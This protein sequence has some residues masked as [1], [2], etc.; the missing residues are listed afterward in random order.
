[1][2]RFAVEDVIA[3]IERQAPT[4]GVDP[5]FARA[6]F[7]AENS[8]DGV[9]RK[10]HV[11]G[12]IKSPVGARGVM[13]TMPDTE[14]GLKKQGFLPDDWQFNP[15]DL[16][17]QVR[18]GL[19]AIQEKQ[20]RQ[21]N[22]GD[23]NELAVMYN[24]STNT[25]RNWRAGLL[26]QVP[27]ETKNY[28]TKVNRALGNTG[29]VMTP[30]QMEAVS[31]ATPGGGGA[32]TATP[33]RSSGSS[34]SSSV[35]SNSYD[36][37]ALAAAMNGGYDLIKAGGSIDAALAD[38]GGA[39]VQR[40]AAEQAQQQQI[41]QT[42]TAQGNLVTAQ[43]AVEAA[44]AQRR[45][46]I[47]TRANINPNEAN[48][49]AQRTMD[50]IMMSTV[51]LETQGAE[52]DQRMSVG[53]FDNP[54]EWLVN[55]TRLPGMVGQYNSK[56]REQNRAI[57]ATRELQSLAQTQ[58]T[59]AQASDADLIAARG[60]AK[61]AEAASLAQERQ[62]EAKAAAAG[63]SI[64]DA[65]VQLAITD[66]KFRTAVTMAELTKQVMSENT[67][68]SERDAARAAEKIQVERVNKWLKMIGSDQQYDSATFKT[69]PAARRDALINMSGTDRIARSLP[70]AVNAVEQLGNYNKIAA[71]GDAA[72]VVWLK[73]TVAKANQMTNEELKL[74]EAQAKITGKVLK[75]EEFMDNNLKRVQ[76]LYQA[77]TLNMRNASD[78]NPMKIDYAVMTKDPVL[79]NSPVSQFIKQYG[80]LSP[81]P[82]F[83][84]VDEKLILDRYIGEVGAGK[85]TTAQAAQELS[86]FY[87]EASEVQL[88]RTKYV[89]FG[90]DKPT[91][92]YTVVIP[93]SGLFDKPLAGGSIDMTNPAALENFLI[94]NVALQA[95][96]NSPMPAFPFMDPLGLAKPGVK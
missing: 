72:A 29:E 51:D 77:E 60:R 2:S 56:V 70:E 47:L 34:T 67:N 18:A 53:F 69:L 54:L 87:R 59:L 15:A 85:K 19:A 71:E 61:V 25:W 24:G 10:T 81:N 74:A 39:I 16:R 14:E 41:V 66:N 28:L 95:R 79:A 44:E 40:Q 43:T 62:N 11:D 57:E 5:K 50:Q 49:L 48:N 46:D 31:R 36:P 13:Q 89:L 23:P 17:G 82:V 37:M 88:Q 94:K 86:Q 83:T 12:T 21:K 75:R 33:N 8:P 92:G 26:D 38:V 91:N 6:I 52:I 45:A 22:K 55:Q 84:K 73:G 35:R 42:A 80:P 20:L 4:V 63:N 96:V 30:Q 76:D 3:E 68:M 90:L 9:L 1:M 65:N 32:P 93:D 64:R 78:S 27:G 7:I 58:I